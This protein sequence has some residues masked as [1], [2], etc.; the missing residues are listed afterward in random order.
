MRYFVF[1]FFLSQSCCNKNE[2][3]SC[4]Q[5]FRFIH[6]SCCCFFFVSNSVLHKIRQWFIGFYAFE[7]VSKLP[8]VVKLTYAHHVFSCSMFQRCIGPF[9]RRMK[10]FDY[11]ARGVRV[12][13][14]NV[15]MIAVV[16]AGMRV[17][18][19]SQNTVTMCHILCCHSLITMITL[20][21]FV[22]AQKVITIFTL[23]MRRIFGASV[24]TVGC[25]ACFWISWW[26]WWWWRW[27]RQRRYGWNARLF[28][29]W[30]GL[31]NFSI[32]ISYSERT[33]VFI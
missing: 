17:L 18:F 9:T 21:E 3:H 31:L 13:T 15:M 19:V 20:F 29:P 12:S 32:A 1:P 23:N 14:L 30:I 11:V 2:W 26:W 27:R 6:F 8:A 22:R 28:L 25:C 5:L 33:H 24:C 10:S 16:L 4:Y 7:T